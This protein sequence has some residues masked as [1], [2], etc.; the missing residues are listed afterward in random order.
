MGKRKSKAESTVSF[1]ITLPRKLARRLDAELLKTKKLVPFMVISR[2]ALIAHAL[3]EWISLLNDPATQPSLPAARVRTRPRMERAA[4]NG[5][6]RLT[7]AKVRAIRN[8]SPLGYWLKLLPIPRKLKQ[9]IRSVLVR[10]LI[11][12]WPLSIPAGNLMA[13]GHKPH[14]APGATGPTPLGAS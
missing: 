12:R 8:D 7:P 3:G 10:L 9:S 11:H 2:S 5:N 14:S 4:S 6:A 13:V 1:N